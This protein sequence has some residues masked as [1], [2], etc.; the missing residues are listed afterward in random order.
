MENI[1]YGEGDLTINWT[2]GGA[3]YSYA[4]D[5]EQAKA[6]LASG[7]AI[8]PYVAPVV[9][10]K[11]ARAAA[12][13]ALDPLVCQIT[14]YELAGLDASQAKAKLATTMAKIDAEFPNV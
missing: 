10:P 6:I 2:Q 3:A 12:L 5:S 4:V 11:V 13:A 7:V 9:D 1:Q 8:A 14:R